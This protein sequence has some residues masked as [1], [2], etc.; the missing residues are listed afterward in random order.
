MSRMDSVRLKIRSKTM[1]LFLFTSRVM[2]IYVIIFESFIR[3][4]FC[5][6]NKFSLFTSLLYM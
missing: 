5:F 6:K 2:F 4:Y 3:I 1:P